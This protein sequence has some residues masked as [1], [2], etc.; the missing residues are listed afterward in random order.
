[1]YAKSPSTQWVRHSHSPWP[2]RR[3]RLLALMGGRR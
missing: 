3:R 1:V 2:G